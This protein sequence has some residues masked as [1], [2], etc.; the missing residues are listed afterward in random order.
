MAWRHRRR[1]Q[2]TNTTLDNDESPILLDGN[3]PRAAQPKN[4]ALPLKPHQLASLHRMMELDTSFMYTYDD[5]EQNQQTTIRSNIG[6]FSDLAGYGKTIT[7][8]SMIQELRDTKRPTNRII[9]SFHSVGYNNYAFMIQKEVNIPRIN[10]M[11][12][13]I[14]PC[15]IVK[16]WANHIEKYTKLTYVLVN[17]K[18]INTCIPEQPQATVD[19]VVLPSNIYNAFVDAHKYVVWDRAVFDEADSIYIPNMKYVHARF[20]WA[21]TATND[22]IHNRRNYGFLTELFR[23]IYTCHEHVT[24]RGKVDFVKQSF[25]INEPVVQYV[26][27]DTPKVIALLENHISEAVLGLL[28]AGDIHGAIVS[29]GGNVDNNDNIVDL[30]TKKIRNSIKKYQTELNLLDTLELPQRDIDQRRTIINERLQSLRTR[31]QSLEHSIKNIASSCCII[32]YDDYKFPT[33]VPCCGT[34]FCGEC[35]L[36][37]LSQNTIC[38]HCRST[39][40]DVSELRTIRGDAT[41]GPPEKPDD[42][43]QFTKT[44]AIINII[45]TNVGGR[46]II[47]SGYESS[48][49]NMV[50]ILGEHDISYGSGSGNVRCQKHFERF[51]KGELSVILLDANYNGAGIELPEATDIIIYH[52]LLPSIE[53][54]VIARAQRPGRVGTLRVWKLKYSTEYNNTVNVQ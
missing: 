40:I 27:C 54:Q 25:E 9:P 10:D 12:L 33:I 30:V 41:T 11:T 24:I 50:K 22:N 1:Q 53:T 44:D 6:F 51:R 52:A 8:L 2:Q 19:V 37:W 49:K 23:T 14:V 26:E 34:V 35:I 16:Q 42:D 3:S 31:Q 17:M 13:L 15:N 47:F 28:N 45:K 43:V 38:A 39:N 32:C 20:I 4:I 5:T 46:F 29:L 21:I 36:R 18:N 7:M 48:F